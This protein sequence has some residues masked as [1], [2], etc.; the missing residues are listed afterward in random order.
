MMTQ[1]YF[2]ALAEC[3]NTDF[4]GD[5]GTLKSLTL[6]H[7]SAYV[8]LI[9]VKFSLVTISERIPKGYKTFIP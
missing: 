4:R 7:L 8:N 2:L 1:S 5:L 9:F 3:T 6:L